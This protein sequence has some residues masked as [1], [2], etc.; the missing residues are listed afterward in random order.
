[1]SPLAILERG[2]AIPYIESG[3]LKSVDDAN[4][5]DSMSVRLHDGTIYAQIVAKEK[6]NE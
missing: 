3:I 6:N 2:Y 5:A 4:I 1:L